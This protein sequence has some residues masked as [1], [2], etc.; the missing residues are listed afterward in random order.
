[1]SMYIIEWDG[2]DAMIESNETLEEIQARLCT[3]W[4][5]ENEVG[6]L[7]PETSTIKIYEA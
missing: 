3:W 7:I 1:M 5:V 6:Q 2:G 4:E